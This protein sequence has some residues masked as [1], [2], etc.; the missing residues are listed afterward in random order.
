MTTAHQN[1]SKYYYVSNENMS[2]YST[3]NP[4]LRKVSKSIP[5][6]SKANQGLMEIQDQ[7]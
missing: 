7:K 3:P 2:E 5:W 4:A 1:H 6:I